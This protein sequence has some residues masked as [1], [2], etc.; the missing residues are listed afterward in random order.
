MAAAKPRADTTAKPRAP[1]AAAGRTATAAD[2]LALLDGAAKDRFPA[3]LYVEG[4]DEALKTAFLAELR[5]AWAV[6][7]P[8]A[9]AA[10][11][12]HPGE[13]DV[14]SILAAYHGISMFTPRELILVLEVEDLGK[15]EKRVAA[16]AAGVARPAGGSCIV[17]VESLAENARKTR[18]PLRTACAARWVAT[19][20]VPR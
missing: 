19:K 6:A 12:M 16:L 18:E 7:V 14:D 8:E 11:V 17:L 13:D 2:P 1:R 15:S 10:H 20:A 4:P 9:P 5:R 3:S